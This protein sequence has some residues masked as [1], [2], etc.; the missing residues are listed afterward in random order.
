MRKC[1]HNDSV[2]SAAASC[3]QPNG[4]ESHSG[5]IERLL[6]TSHN[7]LTIL[8]LFRCW[9]SRLNFLF[10]LGIICVLELPSGRV[11]IQ[12]SGDRDAATFEER[13]D[14]D[15]PVNGQ[16][17]YRL[18][19]QDDGHRVAFVVTVLDN[20]DEPEMT[21]RSSKRIVLATKMNSGVFFSP[22][23]IT[24]CINP[25]T[26]FVIHDLKVW[27]TVLIVVFRIPSRT[28]GMKDEM[29]HSFVRCLQNSKQ[30]SC[31]CPLVGLTGEEEDLFIFSVNL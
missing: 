11:S 12:A 7:S 9:A 6:R 29:W 15:G 22:V 21:V 23:I 25:N 17:A 24:R 28:L 30:D 3:S 27:H 2:P 5:E 26:L 16:L 1:C 14:T 13:I 10:L 19:V 8:S 31:R 20:Y 18:S 4:F